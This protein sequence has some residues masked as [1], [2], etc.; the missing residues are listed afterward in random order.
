[1]TPLLA[2]T[3]V[4]ANLGY[5]AVGLFV[6]LESMGVPSPGE[7]ALVA[8]AIAAAG[9]HLSIELVILVA[10]A[11]AIVGDN[12]GYLIGKHGGR[13]LLERPGPLHRR[14]VALLDAGDTFFARHGAKAVFF[15]RWMALV[16]VTAAWMAGANHMPFRRFFVYNALGGITW[17][18]T[19]GLIAY[20]LGEAGA[21]VLTR[22]G[23]AGAVAAGILLV[24]GVVWLRRRERA[25]AA[26][27]QAAPASA[28]SPPTA[29]DARGPAASASQPASGPPIGVEPRN[30]TE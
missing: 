24:G 17:A 26:R 8:G 7:T 13:R 15:G 14:R 5:F 3:H 6:G 20:A 11:A 12:I 2:L 30:T 9:G 19:V 21:H 18:L 4:P 1:V 25:H 22:V 27:A 29:S 10:A 23:T 16:R 28:E